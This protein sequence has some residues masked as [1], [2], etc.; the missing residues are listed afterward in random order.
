MTN[1]EFAPGYKALAPIMLDIL[2]LHDFVYRN[3]HKSYKQVF[4]QGKL[5]RRGTAENR[6]FPPKQINLPLTKQTAEYEVP[7]GVLYPLLA[8]LRA[9]IEI[10]EGTANWRINAFDFFDAHGHELIESLIDQLENLGSNPQTLGKNKF[11]YN[12]LFNSAK[13]IVMESNE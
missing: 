6:I 8:S 9:L 4:P 2:K 3:F 1:Q 7:T 10:K 11:A 13:I 5:G 12:S